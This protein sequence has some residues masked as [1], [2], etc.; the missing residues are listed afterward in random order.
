MYHR[1][2]YK[3]QNVISQIQGI[4]IFYFQHS[5]L[6]IQRTE[7]VRNHNKG[8]GICHNHR[9]WI[10]L[11]EIL[12]ISRVIRFHM[13]YN[14]IIRFSSIQSLLYVIQPLMSKILIYCIHNCYFLITNHIRI[15]AHSIWNWI[16]PL[17][18]INLMIIDACINN[19]ICN[20]H[21]F[22]P[23]S[24]FASHAF[25]AYLQYTLSI[26]VAQAFFIYNKVFST[27]ESFLMLHF[28]LNFDK[29][30]QIPSAFPSPASLNPS[31]PEFLPQHI[32]L[33]GQTDSSSI[34]FPFLLTES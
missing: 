4:S 33:H 9:F 25:F 17:K 5:S 30:Y 24:F 6:Q 26:S 23:P 2:K 14:Q 15:I 13:L 11:E 21:R 7:E 29:F 10:N 8:L 28:L 3:S 34:P 12:N 22:C 31:V 27:N 19:I 32:D 16:L 20:I 18:Q 1:C